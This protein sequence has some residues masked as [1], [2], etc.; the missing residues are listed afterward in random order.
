MR[1]TRRARAAAGAALLAVAA[2]AG[3]VSASPAGAA[4]V[5][6][7][8]LT[9]V[10]SAVVGIGPGKANQAVG[11]WQ[12]S[13]D[14]GATFQAGD[15][16][17]IEID[18]LDFNSCTGDED[19][20][21]SSL[22]TVTVEGTEVKLV[23][24][25]MSSGPGCG[26]DVLQLNV[27]Q[28]GSTDG[29]AISN[30]AYTA[31]AGTVSGIVIVHP[32]LKGDTFGGIFS[33][34]AFITTAL[35]S[36]NNP[37]HGSTQQDGGTDA[38]SPLVVTEQTATALDGDACVSF[39]GEDIVATPAPTIAVS[40]GTDTA[41][42]TVN[43]ST[44]TI[45]I[46]VTASDPASTSVF[47]LSGIQL[48]TSFAGLRNVDLT[49]DDGD[50]VCDGG[51]DFLDVDKR[52]GYVGNVTR[53][54][55]ADRF[56]TAQVAFESIFGCLDTAVIA[57][58]DQFPDALA[59]AYLAGHEETGIL[60][61]STNSVPAATLNALRNK[62]VKHVFLL[63]G[64]SAISSAVATQLDGTTAFD[65]GGVPTAG[66]LSV[67]RLAGAD[68]F[69]TA[70]LVAEFPGLG[71]AGTADTNND[72]DCDD[73]AP[74]AIV[75]SGVGFADALAAGPL[76]FA[77]VHSVGCGDKNPV[78]LLL[79]GA[80][81]VPAAT[82]AALTNLGIKNVIVVGGTAA[83]SDAAAAQLASDG[84]TV[85]RISGP[86]RTAT[87]AA[88]ATAEIEEWGFNGGKVILA[89]GDDFADAL[90]ASPL[91]FDDGEVIVLTSS[92]TDLSAA[93]TALF[94]GWPFGTVNFGIKPVGG[95]SAISA[96]V[97]Q[98]ALDALSQQ[99][100]PAP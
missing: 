61:T 95:T 43:E 49:A 97:V 100:T 90:A 85:R 58:A 55:G 39:Q 66:T 68:R 78:P 20:V 62:G 22:P 36:G 99:P 80:T 16:I 64:T 18:D 13:V 26:N 12:I 81:Q 82:L 51:D 46:D 33:S 76:S 52:A 45:F 74:T 21:F 9:I 24:T 57:R 92:P 73:E 67:Q 70:Q 41:T 79:T 56:T 27:T 89:R 59:A 8:D 40:G 63:G 11:S 94:A 10:P 96:A 2:V 87:A 86:S 75:A 38:A 1:S 34:N 60:L 42:V 93:T 48:D 47:T 6:P 32:E 7:G 37:P 31:E 3:L 30:V 35:V 4:P 84:R 29:I 72:G 14:P 53:F 17:T 19:I 44:D 88:L 28:G 71:A 98:A 65:C 15:L 54:A 23:S 5:V 77:G 91:T 50:G 69:E 25:L 83:V